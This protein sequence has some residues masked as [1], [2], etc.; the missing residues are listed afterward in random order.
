MSKDKDEAPAAGTPTA[1]Q[2][3]KSTATAAIDAAGTPAQAREAGEANEK[4][5]LAQ[6]DA[7]RIKAAGEQAA[8]QKEAELSA[9]EAQRAVDD[10]VTEAGKTR[11]PSL[12]GPN[13]PEN[14][15][16]GE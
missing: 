1:K 6:D 12:G 16:K 9:L 8:G 10:A 2:G 5:K 4:L 7:A 11:L 14:Q 3:A 15:G 13:L